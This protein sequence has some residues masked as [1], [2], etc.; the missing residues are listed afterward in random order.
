MTGFSP[1]WLA[2][3]EPADHRARH[4]ALQQQ[5]CTRLE[6][7]ARAEQ[8]AVRIIDLGCGSGSNLRALAGSLPDRQH[9]TLVDYDPSLLEAARTAVIGWADHVVAEQPVLRLSKNKKMLEVSFVQVDLA[10]AIETVLGWPADLITAAAFFDL[11]AEPWLVRFCKALRTS[12]YTVLTYDGQEQWLPP[13]PSDSSI[14]KAFHAHQKTD[15]GFGVA[16]G[17]E[18]AGILQRE[19]Q[20]RGFEVTLAPSPWQIDRSETALIQALATGSAAAVR[21]TRLISAQDV[22]LWLA[23]RQKAEHCTVGHWDILATPF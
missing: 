23:A 7:L 6:V 17:P 15:K 18:A 10:L 5:V 9:W 14:L 11:V 16:A 12:L 20:L 3:R 1:E 4:Q 19:L 13:H 2:L 22:D 21:E 8:R